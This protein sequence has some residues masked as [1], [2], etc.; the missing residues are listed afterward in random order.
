MT[1][2]TFQRNINGHRIGFL[3][4]LCLFGLVLFA[5][6]RPARKPRQKVDERVYLIHAD[7]L[8]YD[9][10]GPEPGAQIVTGKVQFSHK[11]SKLWCDSAY[12]YEASNSVKAFGHVRF[13]QGD[14]LSLTC[15]RADYDGQELVMHARMNVVLKHNKQTLYTDSLDYDRLYEF[16]YFF[17]GGRLVDGNDKLSSDWGEYSTKTREAVFYYDVRMRS[18]ERLIETDTLHYDTRTS[19]A[20]ITGKSKITSNQ[21]II[22]TDD[23]FFDSKQ[24]KAR[25]YNRSTVINEGKTIVG[26]SLYFDDNT[27]VAEGFGNVVYIDTQNKNELRCG[28]LNY[29]KISGYGYATID[30]LLKDFSQEDTLYL[31]GDSLKLYT[32][33][34]NTDSV[35]RVVHCFDKVRAYRTD[36]QA[37]CDSLVFN[38]KDSCMTMYRDPIVWNAG[39]QMLG[40]KIMVFMN[41]S[42]IREAHVIGQA[43]SIE[44]LPDSIHYNQVSSTNMFSYFVDGNPR[45]SDAVGNVRAIY[46]PVD[47]KD[48]TL[49]GLNYTETDT[50]RMYMSDQRKMERIWMPK[51]TGTLYPMTQI[52]PSKL[53]LTGFAW[54]DNIR[55]TG[56]EDVFVWRG[57]P[58]GTEL[59]N[60]ERVAMP[61]Q[62]LDDDKKGNEA[63]GDDKQ[64][65]GAVDDDKKDNMP[66]DEDKKHEPADEDKNEELVVKEENS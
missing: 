50:M 5:A 38:S 11:G 31:H 28:H 16:A 24:D 3:A 9:F 36:M 41:D 19:L 39:R 1:N 52:P 15:D 48:T 53:K 37:V 34:I 46:Y 7:V 26:D 18:P 33:N 22:Y 10:F 17:D 21:G 57:K 56:P 6:S 43:F 14:T 51:A 65:N 55:P 64:E 47:D 13:K 23:G 58:A 2:N 59:R 63:V 61:L 62:K 20:H 66:A 32:Y 44:Q 42:T 27:G 8:K 40:E 35:Y 29:N 54:F 30:A 12:F 49:I 25:L 60:V 4:V 45:R